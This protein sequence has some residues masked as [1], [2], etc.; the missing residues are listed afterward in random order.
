[1]ISSRSRFTLIALRTTATVPFIQPT[2]LN[3]V[4]AEACSIGALLDF[5]C[6]YTVPGVCKGAQSLLRCVRR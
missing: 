1:V 4:F 3:L 5:L 6:V 2:A